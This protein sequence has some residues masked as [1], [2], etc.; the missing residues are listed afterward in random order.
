MPFSESLA[1]RYERG[2]IARK[3]LTLSHLWIATWIR[4]CLCKL[5]SENGKDADEVVT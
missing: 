3:R 2:I 1:A 5:K 4:G